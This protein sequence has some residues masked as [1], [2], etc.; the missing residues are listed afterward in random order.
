MNK[1]SDQEA[2]NIIVS[3]LKRQGCMSMLEKDDRVCAYRGK[4]DK[5]CAIGALIPN[6]MYYHD[7][8][9]HGIYYILSDMKNKHWSEL[10]EFF[11]ELNMDLLNSMQDIHDYCDVDS[12]DTCFSEIATKYNLTLPKF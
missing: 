4:S 10:I 6:S 8:E 1:L 11:S 2:F 3:H 9:N 12:W 5:M 7:M